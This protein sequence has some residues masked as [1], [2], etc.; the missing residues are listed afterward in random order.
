MQ[1]LGQGA[2]APQDPRQAEKPFASVRNWRAE[3][4]PAKRT[5]VIIVASNVDLIIFLPMIAPIKMTMLDEGRESSVP[6]ILP[7]V[8]VLAGPWHS[9]LW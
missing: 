1:P 8:W 4:V 6:A 7:E 3:T 2:L 9:R 5:A